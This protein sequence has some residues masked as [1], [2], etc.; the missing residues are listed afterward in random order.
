MKSNIKRKRRRISRTRKNSGRAVYTTVILLTSTLFLIGIYVL[1][2][3]LDIFEGSRPSSAASSGDT[4]SDGYSDVQSLP[5]SGTSGP[6]PVPTATTAPAITTAPTP[7]PTSTPVTPGALPNARLGWSYTPSGTEGVPATTNQSRI[8]LCMRYG[9]IWQADTSVKKI[10]ITMDIGYEYNN[11]TTKILDIAKAK[12]FKIAFFVVGTNFLKDNLKPMFLRMYKEGHLVVNHSWNHPMYWKMFAE[13]GKQGIAD[14][15][16]KTED[17]Y[18]AITGA[19]MKKYMRFPSG[20]YSEATLNV[21]KEIGYRPVFWSFAHRDWLIDA[22]PDPDVSLQ[23]AIKG[24]HN[25]AVLLL[26]T[27]SNTNVEILPELVD[28]IRARGYEIGTIDEIG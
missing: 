2:S 1:G 8:D 6:T 28:E 17:A 25:G 12:N 4:V 27:V 22:Q 14:D 23:Y 18:F 9:G 16:K 21:M 20:E 19:T 15:L 11:N 24:L 10:Y 7:K 5:E 3:S 13:S 26:H